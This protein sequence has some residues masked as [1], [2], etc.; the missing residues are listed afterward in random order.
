MK[1]SKTRAGTVY[2]GGSEIVIHPDTELGVDKLEHRQIF[3][4]NQIAD[5]TVVCELVAENLP[6]IKSVL[7]IKG[8][9]LRDKF[10]DLPND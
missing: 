3:E 10:Y 6:L 5:Y 4:V 9:P 2:N 1:M 8:E 7:S